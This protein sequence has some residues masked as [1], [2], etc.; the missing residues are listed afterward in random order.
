[1]K[2]AVGRARA[3][4]ACSEDL[5]TLVQIT[6]DPELCVALGA[7]IY[8]GMLEGTIPGG[9]ELADGA[10]SAALHDRHTGF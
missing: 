6:V 8:G 2:D 4:A 10:Y 7:T 1:M 3:Q 5:C 9:V